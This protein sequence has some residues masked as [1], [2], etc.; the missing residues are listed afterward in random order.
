MMPDLILWIVVVVLAIWAIAAT[1]IAVRLQN[2]LDVSEMK[3]WA[4]MGWYDATAKAVYKE[5]YWHRSNVDPP[6]KVI[7]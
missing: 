6:K 3:R 1:V 4:L 5:N 2:D 7:G